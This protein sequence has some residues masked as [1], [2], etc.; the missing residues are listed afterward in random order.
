MLLQV[1]LGGFVSG[2]LLLIS[3]F[4]IKMIANYILVNREDSWV[5][6]GILISML[7]LFASCSKEEVYEDVCG[8]CLV[9]FE[10]PFDKDSNGYYHAK[11]RYNKSG[12]GRFSIDT[13]ATQSEDVYIYSIFK[14]D[15]IVSESMM[16]DMVQESRLNH[17]DEGYTKRIVGPVLTKFIGDTL[18]VNVETYWEG[19]ASWQ[20]SKN[21]LKFIIE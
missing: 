13:Y 16:V 4:F 2:V 20:V 1:F 15:I 9:K 18:T 19:N 7:F 17:D 11:V 12:A 5:G 6:I 21:T 10:V 8:E 3:I 14:G